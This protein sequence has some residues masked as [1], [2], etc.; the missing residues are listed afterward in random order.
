V[1]WKREEKKVPGEF[2]VPQQSLKVDLQ[3]L[4]NAMLRQY[5]NKYVVIREAIQHSIDA[6][7]KHIDVMINDHAGH[8]HTKLKGFF[9]CKKSFIS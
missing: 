9:G 3:N 1:F 5:K 4:I 7:A 8:T 6:R 2:D